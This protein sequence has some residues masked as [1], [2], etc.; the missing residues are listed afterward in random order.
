MALRNDLREA[1][2]SAVT[3]VPVR[4]LAA[5]VDRLI[6][7]YRSGGV[8]PEH[9]LRS[10]ADVTAYA[11][12]R[13]PATYAAVRTAMAQLIPSRFAPETHVDIGGG[14]G[15]AAWAA[16]D[17]FGT[18][19]EISVLDRVDDALALG[20]RLAARADAAVLRSATWRR[21]TIGEQF[22]P[23]DL[24]TISY[25]LAELTVADQA[26]LVRRAGVCAGA[27]L[28]VVEPGT[29][30]GYGRVLAARDVLLELGLTV[31]APCPHQATCPIIPGRDWCHFAA[32]VNRSSLH[33]RLKAAELGYQ[34]EKFSYVAASPSRAAATD[35]PGRVLRRPEHRK[36]LVS[37]L[38][39]TPTEGL[40]QQTVS[41][42]QGDLYRAAR[43][44][45]W[46][47]AWPRP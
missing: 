35:A 24:V 3:A 29:P 20:R 37:M 22:P 44:T 6:S 23:A 42:R 28:L 30:A 36:G 16:A 39:C 46:G 47:D 27:L 34:D 11:A 9:I 12:Y 26:E 41:K 10:V 2:D 7:V 15:A 25:V 45:A 5:S 13:M 43:D 21:S 1:I 38:V 18:L 32:R 33:R 31:V 40:V 14:S 4:D 8:A 17:A 19:R